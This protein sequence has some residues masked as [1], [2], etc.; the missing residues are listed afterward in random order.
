[1]DAVKSWATMLCVV[2][3]GCALVQMLAPKDGMG[4]ILKLIIAAFFLCC[5]VSPLLSIKSLS[6]LNLDLLPDE[7]SADLL[8]ERVNEQLKQQMA[9]AVKKVADKSLKN[10]GI[11]AEKVIVETDTSEEGGIYIRQV[12]LYLN[13]QNI[14]KALTARQVMEQ[15]LGVDVSVEEEES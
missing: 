15:Q 6:S 3:V 7:I 1:M 14:Q 2:A 8:Q 5:M 13:S 11:T 4:K 12:I 9:A 10:Y